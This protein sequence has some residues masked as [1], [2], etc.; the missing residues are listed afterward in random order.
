MVTPGAGNRARLA[1]GRMEQRPP[2]SLTV[3]RLGAMLV[4]LTAGSVARAQ[5]PCSGQ[6][7]TAYVDCKA[8][9]RAANLVGK[10]R[11]NVMRACRAVFRLQQEACA[12]GLDVFAATVTTDERSYAPGEIVSM[13]GSGWAPGETVSLVVTAIPRTHDPVEL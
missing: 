11:R 5:R 7:A 12:S 13:S 6:A 2:R 4:L 9:V 10:P 3:A 1:L 8:A